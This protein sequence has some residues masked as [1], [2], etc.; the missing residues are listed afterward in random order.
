MYSRECEER[1][2][3][4]QSAPFRRS[5]ANS[6]ALEAPEALATCIT[7]L[8]SRSHPSGE[9][10]LPSKLS[11]STAVQVS[12]VSFD[13]AASKSNSLANL[14]K[15]II[16]ATLPEPAA[17]GRLLFNRMN[18]SENRSLNGTKNRTLVTIQRGYCPADGVSAKSPRLWSGLL[19]L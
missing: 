13:L 18:E 11:L 15:L 3:Q 4:R 17:R 12:S 1:Q 8:P 16:L 2:F 10:S 6:E 7:V 5:L 9:H 14:L 19:G